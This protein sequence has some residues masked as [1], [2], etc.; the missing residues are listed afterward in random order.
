LEMDLQRVKSGT[1]LQT[2]INILLKKLCDELE[3]AG[4]TEYAPDAYELAVANCTIVLG[5]NDNVQ[6]SPVKQRPSR[7]K[8]NSAGKTADGNVG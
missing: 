2:T 5:G 7:N 3:R 4:I 8:R 1:I 6:R